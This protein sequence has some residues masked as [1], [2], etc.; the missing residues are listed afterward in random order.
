MRHLWALLL[1][2]CALTSK[3]PPVEFRYFS[4]APV[5]SPD[6]EPPRGPAE[7]PL[8]LGRV[9]SSTNLR[10]PILYRRTWIEV[11]EY[12]TLRWTE[13][14]EVYL[15]R[16]LQRA[17][18]ER[19][20]FAQSLSPSAPTL[21]V[22]LIDFEQVMTAGK[23]AGRVR[24]RYQLHRELEVLAAG[25]IT[26]ERESKAG[27]EAAVVAIGAALD[28]ATDELAELVAA[29]LV[30]MISRTDLVEEHARPEHGIDQH[31]DIERRRRATR[32]GLCPRETRS[33]SPSSAGR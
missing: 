24:L 9:T 23:H 29:R 20:R 7:T 3:G 19:E 1:C 14:P 4:P 33:S 30:G 10:T 26:A 16:S 31:S 8:T 25:S 2:G 27:I 22:E 6:A 28:Q 11:G 17:L 15:R 13:N 32:A 5:A 21:E 12:V 18:F